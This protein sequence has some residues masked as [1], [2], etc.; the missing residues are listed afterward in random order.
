MAGNGSVKRKDSAL[1][2]PVGQGIWGAEVRKAEDG[3]A[4]WEPLR[5]LGPEDQ[6]HAPEWDVGFSGEPVKGLEQQ[7]LAGPFSWDCLWGWLAPPRTSWSSPKALVF[8]PTDR[9]LL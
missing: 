8:I 7:D 6:A 9:V 1:E 4:E 2:T 5:E 3:G